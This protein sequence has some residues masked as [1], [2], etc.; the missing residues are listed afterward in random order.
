MNLGQ[1]R[2]AI[3]IR[4]GVPDNDALYTNDV[5]LNL[6]NSSLR[7]ID[8]VAVWRWLEAE[9][10]LNTEA[11]VRNYDLPANYRSS[12]FVV[13]TFGFE[14]ERAT[15]M[16]H[17]LLRG[18]S[19]RPKVWDVY[20]DNLRLAPA[21][22]AVYGLT[23][24]YIKGEIALAADA[25]VPLLPEVWHQ[26]VVEQATYLAQRRWGNLDE[27]GSALAAYNAILDQMRPN[28]SAYTGTTGGGQVPPLTEP[29]SEPG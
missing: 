12:I 3:R 21:P 4:L 19:G 14:L 28:A 11:G 25:D 1:F 18:A 15:A 17:R 29:A 7:I 24:A 8:G 2:N 10:E 16:H 20:G 27:A 13:D 26:A 22:D 5:L 6:V 9:Q 23:H